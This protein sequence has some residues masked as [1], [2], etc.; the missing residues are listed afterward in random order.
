MFC[1]E[2][3]ATP[4][5]TLAQYLPEGT[6][7]DPFQGL[8]PDFIPIA[9]SLYLEHDLATTAQVINVSQIIL[10]AQELRRCSRELPPKQPD[11]DPGQGQGPNQAQDSFEFKKP[12]SRTGGASDEEVRAKRRCAANREYRA[13]LAENRR[14]GQVAARKNDGSLDSKRDSNGSPKSPEPPPRPFETTAQIEA[15]AR[16]WRS[17]IAVVPAHDPYLPILLRPG[18][19]VDTVIGYAAGKSVEQ[20]L[21]IFPTLW[22]SELAAARACEH[23]KMHGPFNNAPKYPTEMPIVNGPEGEALAEYCRSLP[24]LKLPYW[25][26]SSTRL[27]ADTSNR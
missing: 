1:T 23:E 9:R 10:S 5:Q 7:D 11:Q 20:I 24:K 27:P 15:A 3:V 17:H 8:D 13:N 12:K 21:E 19:R 6:E 22:K 14:L 16:N 26:E 4:L 25:N 18:L 2:D